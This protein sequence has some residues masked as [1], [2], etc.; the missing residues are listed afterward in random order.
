MWRVACKEE[1]GRQVNVGIGILR[2]DV[3]RK[4]VKQGDIA[5]GPKTDQEIGVNRV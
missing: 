5:R 2:K 4:P 3:K 1:R